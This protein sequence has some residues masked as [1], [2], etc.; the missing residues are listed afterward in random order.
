MHIINNKN[1]RYLFELRFIWFFV[2][3]Y[4]KTK[5]KSMELH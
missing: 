1:V 5:G 2:M 4:D 3:L